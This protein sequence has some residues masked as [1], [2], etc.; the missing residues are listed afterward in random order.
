MKVER[1]TYAQNV[2]KPFQCKFTNYILSLKNILKKLTYIFQ[3]FFLE[4]AIS[5]PISKKY[6]KR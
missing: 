2:E 6:M 4:N 5:I 3:N 1:I